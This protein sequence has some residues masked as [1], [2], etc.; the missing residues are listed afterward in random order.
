MNGTAPPSSAEIIV[1]SRDVEPAA[2]APSKKSR[3]R[4][5][6]SAAEKS[7]EDATAA[8]AAA[9]AADE[10][11]IPTV[12]EKRARLLAKQK[13]IFE[14]L[15]PKSTRIDGVDFAGNPNE[16]GFAP[17][18][19]LLYDKFART[20][21]T[22]FVDCP[23]TTTE[24][25]LLRERSQNNFAAYTWL[26]AIHLPYECNNREHR[27]L[28]HR[29]NSTLFGSCPNAAYYAA[30]INTAMKKCFCHLTN[31]ILLCNDLSHSHTRGGWQ[32][33][34]DETHT[35]ANDSY[36]F[37]RDVES[38]D[39]YRDRL[40][41]GSY[42]QNIVATETFGPASHQRWEALLRIAMRHCVPT[43]SIAL[44]N[45]LDE[46]LRA[47]SALS[48][49]RRCLDCF[50][51]KTRF[52]SMRGAQRDYRLSLIPETIFY[53]KRTP[54]SERERER[55][56]EP[57]FVRDAGYLDSNHPFHSRFDACDANETTMAILLFVDATGNSMWLS[58]WQLWSTV[59][60][61]HCKTCIHC[62]RRLVEFLSCI[63]LL[64]QLTPGVLP[65]LFATN[66]ERLLRRLR[67]LN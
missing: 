62:R 47:S 46:Q 27:E 45:T 1:H 2:A 30:P 61:V 15:K 7:E 5:A 57:R 51:Y 35:D 32:R 42:N 41:F 39:R 33:Q 44:F 20:R 63:T 65:S 66:T 37:E 48:A 54:M 60:V 16:D 14:D 6:E 49:T 56:G 29:N 3:K 43:H 34:I 12:P 22:V 52:S 36:R 17:F 23:L 58:V 67:N 26:D 8:A 13:A 40:T 9:A 24:R 38:I 19:T 64:G 31:T 59:L 25:T 18:W 10:F 50:A 21:R 53:L 55:V 4:K 11:R 28:Q